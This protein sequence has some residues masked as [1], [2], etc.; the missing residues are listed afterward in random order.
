MAIEKALI[1][2]EILE[3]SSIREAA[4]QVTNSGA[5]NEVIYADS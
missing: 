5:L 2:E 4:L 3:R 1:N